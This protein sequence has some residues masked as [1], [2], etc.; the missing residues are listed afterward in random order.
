M[1]DTNSDPNL[2]DFPIPA[3]D[4]ASKSISLILE[5]ICGAM[6]EGLE[7]RKMEREKEGDLGKGKKGDKSEDADDADEDIDDEREKRGGLRKSLTL[8]A[9]AKKGVVV[10]I[11]ELEEEE[12]EEKEEEEKAEEKSEEKSEEKE[13]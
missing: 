13:V 5:I 12:V 1:V 2:V 10:D 7:E 11:E 4:D 8:K 6:Q 3:N 9:P